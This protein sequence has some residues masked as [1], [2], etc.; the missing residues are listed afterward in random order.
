MEALE[1][2]CL[3]SV[4]INEFP[5]P[6]PNSMT[7]SIEAAPDGNVWFM[8]TN[9]NTLGRITPAGQITEVPLPVSAG[10]ANFVFGP[11]G[12]IWFGLRTDIAEITPQGGLLHDYA[13]PSASPPG[14]PDTGLIV[15]MGPDGNIWYTEP[16][17][18]DL[19][20]RLT[21]DGQITEFP[22]PGERVDGSADII[23]GPDGNLWFAA[24]A[25]NEIGRV[26]VDGT[27]DIF[28][29]RSQLSRRAPRPHRRPGR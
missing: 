29:P 26:H 3:P 2:R 15:T 24:T 12:N 8:E 20:G 11:D 1:N 16:Y 13:I 23:T 19:I 17:T 4:T 6:A 9:R 27:M 21:P 14:I 22:I 28:A 5:L 25:G 10:N 18:K 7:N